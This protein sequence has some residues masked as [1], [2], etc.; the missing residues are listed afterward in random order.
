MSL[1]DYCAIQLLDG[2]AIR[3]EHRSLIGSSKWQNGR[4]FLVQP[5]RHA[6][7]RRVLQ[8]PFESKKAAA[9]HNRCF[10]FLVV[11]PAVQAAVSFEDVRKQ[12]VHQIRASPSVSITPEIPGSVY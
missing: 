7:G 1:G 12:L 8:H 2:D 11:I 10:D 4:A 6:P 9:G 5:H 3:S